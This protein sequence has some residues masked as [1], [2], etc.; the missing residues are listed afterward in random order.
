MSGALRKVT[1][2]SSSRSSSHRSSTPTPSY[3]HQ[4]E[5]V[6]SQVPEEQPAQQQEEKAPND[7]HLDIRGEQELQAYNILKGRTF[8]HTWEFDEDLLEK[9]G[10]N[11]EFMSVWKAVR[12][13]SFA[14]IS[15][16]GSRDLTIQF[17]CTLV[18]TNDGI[19]FRFFG[20]EFS[21]SWKELSTVLGFHHRCNLDLEQATKGYHRESFWHTIS[22]L[23]AYMQPVAMISNI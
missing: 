13:P 5:Q 6:E 18:E 19:S 22:G 23:N 4:D 21:L 7:S 1:R 10:M 2:S 9:T 8:G 15:E 14:E 3:T 16:L 17:L 12:W 20:E 11:A